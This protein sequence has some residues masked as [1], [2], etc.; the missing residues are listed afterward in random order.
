MK[1]IGKINISALVVLIFIMIA[2]GTQGIQPIT[3]AGKPTGT[4]FPHA[5]IVAQKPLKLAQ[6][7]NTSAEDGA[8][9]ESDNQN[10]TT[11]PG[12]DPQTDRNERSTNSRAV[13]LKDFKPSEEIAA[14]Q[15]VDFPVDI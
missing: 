8:Q 14:E 13:P 3:P 2:P 15:A 11:E 5:S 7:E 10:R 6:N 12:S 9:K 1:S 4:K